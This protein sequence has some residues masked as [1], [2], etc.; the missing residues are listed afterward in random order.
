MPKVSVLCQTVSCTFCGFLRMK[1]LPRPQL[2]TRAALRLCIAATLACSPTIFCTRQE[3]PARRGE[4]DHDWH[5][6]ACCNKGLL[7]H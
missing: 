5:H 4:D 2:A 1:T 6:P 7:S 3:V